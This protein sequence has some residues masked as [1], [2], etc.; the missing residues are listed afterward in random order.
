MIAMGTVVAAAAIVN[1]EKKLVLL[2]QRSEDTSYPLLWC[3]PGGKVEVDESNRDALRRELREEIRVE[4]TGWKGVT[5]FYMHNVKSTRTGAMMTVIC[6]L[7]P[8]HLICGQPQCGDK[9]AGVGW[10]SASDIRRISLTPADRANR[11]LFVST[12]L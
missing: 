9:V 10:F 8:H 2:T 6:F 7:V 4:L 1:I 3:T 12:L 5:R 11:G